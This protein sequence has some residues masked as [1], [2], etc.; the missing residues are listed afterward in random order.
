MDGTYLKETPYCETASKPDFQTRVTS[1]EVVACNRHDRK[2][3]MALPPT[4]QTCF[5]SQLMMEW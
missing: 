4:A 1:Q 5:S 3:E 2:A